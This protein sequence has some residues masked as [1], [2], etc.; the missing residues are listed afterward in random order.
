MT[1]GPDRTRLWIAIEDLFIL[2]SV[3]AIWPVILGWE[4]WVWEATK[5]IAAVGLIWIFVRRLRRY[6]RRQEAQDQDR[7]A[8]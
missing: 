8:N 4:G 3:F 1:E 7:A 2:V 5:Y 6:Q